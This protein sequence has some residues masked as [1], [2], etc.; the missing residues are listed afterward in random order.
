M[1]KEDIQKKVIAEARNG[2]DMAAFCGDKIVIVGTLDG[3]NEE[4]LFVDKSFIRD[5]EHVP[6]FDNEEEW[7]LCELLDVVLLWR[8]DEA[9]FE[10]CWK[11]YAQALKKILAIN[12]NFDFLGTPEY[13]TAV[14]WGREDLAEVAEDIAEH[15]SNGVK[16]NYFTDADYIIINT[17]EY[18]IADY[19]RSILA[20]EADWAKAATM[21]DSDDGAPYA[22]KFIID[23]TDKRNALIALIDAYNRAPAPD[24]SEF[25]RAVREL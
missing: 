3:L 14:Y 10:Y 18:Y 11:P 17:S 20:E 7:Q 1:T 12:S 6:E 19:L 24:E 22:G 16:I 9:S 4:S 23:D 2:R 8:V 13:A 5:N 15:L 21:D 25:M